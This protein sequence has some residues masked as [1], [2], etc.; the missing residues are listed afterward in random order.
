M[1]NTRHHGVDNHLGHDYSGKY[2]C[3]KQY[4]QGYGKDGRRRAAKERRADDKKESKV[5]YD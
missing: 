2:K 1:S 4:A 5:V 3:N